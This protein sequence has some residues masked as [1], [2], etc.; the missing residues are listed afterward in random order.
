M[1]G[2]ITNN[3]LT[4]YRSGL[5]PQAVGI[6]WKRSATVFFDGV[7]AVALTLYALFI[8]DFLDTLNN[9]LTLSVAVL[10]P[11][12]ALYGTD[13][14]LRRNRYDGEQLHDETPGSRYWY[15]HGVNWAGVGALVLGT[16]AALLCVDTPVLVGPV[17]TAP[18]GACGHRGAGRDATRAVRSGAAAHQLIRPAVNR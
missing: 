9:V 10:G 11:S 18:D 8:S 1:I 5:A 17:A 15:R 6:P 12:M 14:L 3:V 7:T 13:I 16:A 2:S 4:A